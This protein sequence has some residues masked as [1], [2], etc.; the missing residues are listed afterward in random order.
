LAAVPKLRGMSRIQIVIK[1]KKR[2][3]LD[4]VLETTL[5]K[6]RANKKVLVHF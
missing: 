4:K 6:V 1:A 2:K 3:D 5:G